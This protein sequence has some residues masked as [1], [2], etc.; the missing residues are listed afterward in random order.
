MSGA[1]MKKILGSHWV[2]NTH[3]RFVR[4]GNI[5]LLHS[6]FIC[7]TLLLT[8]WLRRHTSNRTFIHRCLPLLHAGRYDILW[9]HRRSSEGLHASFLLTLRI[10]SD[11][12]DPCAIANRG[13]R[14]ICTHRQISILVQDFFS[15]KICTAVIRGTSDRRKGGGKRR[16]DWWEQ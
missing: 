2:K 4:I 10:H 7:S 6:V 8:G 13:E 5:L 15:N 3:N 12:S 9:L 1:S 16:R 11:L 14:N